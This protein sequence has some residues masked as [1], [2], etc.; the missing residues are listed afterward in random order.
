MARKLK[1]LSRKFYF[2]RKIIYFCTLKTH[3]AG[4]GSSFVNKKY[5][6]TMESKEPQH[7]LNPNE[8]QE[9]ANII[10]R[11]KANSKLILG[12]S[13]LLIVVIVGVLAW[14]FIAQRGSRAAD[15]AVAKA[16]L[17]QNDSTALVLYKEAAEHGYKSGNRAR[18]EVATRLYGQGKYEEA[19]EYLKK[20]SFSDHIVK[21]GALTLEGDCYVNLKQYPEALKVYDKAI[22]AADENPAIVPLVLVKKANIYRNDK[23]YE[24]ETEALRQIV[25]DYPQFDQMSQ[26]DIRKLYER[27]KASAGK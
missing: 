14:F 13:I 15:E 16:D 12:L 18:L 26:A 9:G 21:A 5:Y 23:N 19:L 1:L 22:S 20:A 6:N 24:A 4:R 25:E 10:A 8:A 11:A 17:E 3:P 2:L 7:P 27:A